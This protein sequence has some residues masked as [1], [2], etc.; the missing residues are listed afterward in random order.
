MSQTRSKTISES[1]RKYPALIFSLIFL[2]GILLISMTRNSQI[3][4]VLALYLCI[5]LEGISITAY[6]ITSRDKAS[7]NS[8]ETRKSMSGTSGTDIVDS[9]NVYV[10]YAEK[11]S[12]HSRRELAFIIRNLIRNKE[13]RGKTDFEIDQV[14]QSDLNRVV[15]RYTDDYEKVRYSSARESRTERE[16]YVKSLER[17]I[18]KLSAS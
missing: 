6:V 3:I 5:L 2:V 14:F 17:L 16:A 4:L 13:S 15:T 18:S 9:M 11:G 1:S 10:T 7:I 12:S 8:S